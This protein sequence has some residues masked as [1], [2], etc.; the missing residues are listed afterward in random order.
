MREMFERFSA[1]CAATAPDFWS[2]ADVGD[3][4]TA[5]CSL[6]G[7][8]AKTAAAWCAIS[9]RSDGRSGDFKFWV[10]VFQQLGKFENK[11]EGHRL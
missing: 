4:S 8:H 2:D 3:I 7:Q 9:A 11:C 10:R 6:Y 5:V 1:G